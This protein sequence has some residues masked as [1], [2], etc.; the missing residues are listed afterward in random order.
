MEKNIADQQEFFAYL[1]KYLLQQPPVIE[2]Y[3]YSEILKKITDLLNVDLADIIKINNDLSNTFSIVANYDRTNSIVL[4]NILP[5]DKT[6]AGDAFHLSLPVLVMNLSNS[7]EKN[8]YEILTSLHIESGIW[9]VIKN[10]R[11]NWGIL[12][13][14]SKSNKYFSNSDVSFM[15]S[16]ANIIGTYQD[17]NIFSLQ[18]KKLNQFS[19]LV[20]SENDET[21]FFSQIFYD[22]LNIYEMDNILLLKHEIDK[23]QFKVKFLN[24][25]N[26]IQHIDFIDEKDSPMLE[27][28]LRTNEVF[29]FINKGDLDYSYSNQLF[30]G[31]K[32]FQGYNIKSGILSPIFLKNERWGFILG[33]SSSFIKFNKLDENFFYALSNIVS[34]YIEKNEKEQKIQKNL[35]KQKLLTE[36]SNFAMTA[37]EQELFDKICKEVCL[38]FDAQITGIIKFD[39]LKN[40]LKYI[41]KFEKG[42][43]DPI[44]SSKNDEQSVAGY[45]I[46]NKYPVFIQDL[47]N[48]P[49]FQRSP[50]IN[51]NIKSGINCPIINSRGAW[52]VFGALSQEENRIIK[53][54]ID[55]F[56]NITNIIGL[57]LER[58]EI[59]DELIKNNSFETTVRLASGIAHDFNN[60]LSLIQGNIELLE[61]DELSP[62]MEKNDR[63]KSIFNLKNTLN[64][65]ANLIKQL[66]TISRNEVIKY[67]NININMIIDDMSN[68][69]EEKINSSTFKGI[70]A[71]FNLTPNLWFVVGDSTQFTQL[72]LNL[73]TNAI[74]AISSNQGIIKITTKN[75]LLT[76]SN[77]TYEISL[78]NLNL[79]F[80]DCVY[81]SIQDN[82]IG[83]EKQFVDQIFTPYIRG[84]KVSSTTGVNLG[85]G[86]SIV[87][88]IVTQMNGQI[89]VSSEV[90]HG[91]KFEIF[92]PAIKEDMSNFKVQSKVDNT[93][94]KKEIKHSNSLKILMVDDN[95]EF[96]DVVVTFLKL[97]NFY[98]LTAENGKKGLEPFKQNKDINLIITDVIMPEMNGKDFIHEIRKVDKNMPIIIISGNA[99]M[100]LNDVLDKTILFLP[101]P[102]SIDK[103]YSFILNL[104][105]IP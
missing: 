10:N 70:Q 20:L 62:K 100:P 2:S 12:G 21:K 86:L 82:G 46:L 22:V 31:N 15:Q 26:L 29:S 18:Q 85:L 98:T 41:S 96:L 89:K 54:D 91:T 92:L 90:N 30:T 9:V 40:D 66:Q 88:G 77:S 81:V 76:D 17:Q 73:I 48:D 35:A 95:K 61:Q 65:I 64:K 42:I 51:Y 79:P 32:K 39:P 56:Q 7:N 55:F 102:F 47:K 4:P 37:E 60:Y 24:T 104:L 63:L 13:T 27:I 14:M 5:M 71:S 6:A 49:R 44:V 75:L 28:G 38:L 36:L 97:K 83:M 78:S 25:K 67:S 101:K 3:F 11:G 33:T 45:T 74:E 16:L 103:L 23:K 34:N 59:A 105:A 43:K 80:S 1:T 87:Y 8:R 50:F 53:E 84:K 68:I 93:P 69:I 57:Y 19:E 94:T 58:K 72:I 99:S 52:G